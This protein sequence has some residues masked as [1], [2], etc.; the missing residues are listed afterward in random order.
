MDDTTTLLVIVA[1]VA[2][3]IVTI[4]TLLVQ[5]RARIRHERLV[6]RFGP[7]YDR[8]VEEQGSESVADRVLAA[9]ADRVERFRARELGAS[10]RAR[11]NAAWLKIQ[12]Q[13]VDDPALAVSGAN[14]LINEVLRASGY[15]VESFEQRVADLSV[16]HPAVIQ[17]YRAAHA[18]A[19]PPRDGQVNTEDLR[20][21]VVHYRFLFADL[22]RAPEPLRALRES[23]A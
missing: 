1:F 3:A 20:Q 22:L 2:V 23:H 17:H 11:F 4:A 16:E 5:H 13:F 12:A 9:R 7:E 10:E 19:T 21:A 6:E 15:P 18:L 14:D 8:A